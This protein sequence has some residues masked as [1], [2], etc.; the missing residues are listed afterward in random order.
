MNLKVFAPGA[1]CVWRASL[2]LSAREVPQT[3]GALGDQRSTGPG[4]IKRDVDSNWEPKSQNP[5]P[6]SAA[7]G[8]TSKEVAA[9]EAAALAARVRCLVGMILRERSSVPPATCVQ[10][11]PLRT[12]CGER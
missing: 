4:P 9:A 5:A 6:G 11:K 1:R 3:R 8:A 12:F 7:R 2:L 10:V